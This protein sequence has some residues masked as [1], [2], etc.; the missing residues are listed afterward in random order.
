MVL[1]GIVIWHEFFMIYVYSSTLPQ[2]V[3]GFTEMTYWIF[4]WILAYGSIETNILSAV[5]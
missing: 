5:C 2:S 4:F 1:S 3:N